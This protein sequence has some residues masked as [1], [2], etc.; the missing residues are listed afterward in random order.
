MGIIKIQILCALSCLLSPCIIAQPNSF[1]YMNREDLEGYRKGDWKE[2]MPYAGKEASTLRQ[3]VASHDFL[4]FNVR[5]NP[6]ETDN[7]F[8]AKLKKA[9]IIA[10]NSHFQQLVESELNQAQSG[11]I[12]VDDSQLEYVVEGEGKA[13]LVIGSSIY[14]PR[15]FSDKLRKH[16]KMYFV[17]MKWFAKGYSPEDLDQVNIASIVQDVEQIREALGLEKPLMMGHSI[18]GTIATEY[19]KKFGTQVSG[20]IVIGSPAE[21][22]NASYNEKAASLWA[23]AS[24]KRKKI[25]EENWGKTKEIDRLTGQEEA[26]ARYNNMSPQYWYNP[27]YD[28]SWLWA[29]MT[30]HSEVTQHLFTKVFHDYDMFD[31][32]IAIDVPVFLGLGKYDYV[33]PYTLWRSSYESIPDFHRVFFEKSGHTPQLEEVELFD[34]ELLDWLNHRF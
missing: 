11:L 12:T 24:P 16:L 33:I 10:D 6:K 26:S 17:D 19:V 30:V 4:L 28:A 21:W 2:K 3:A 31:P 20:L 18:H 29:D 1:L 14:Y 7:L 22:G 15:T 9:R 8:E 13:C 32:P 23:S 25:Q 34:K 5:E 27:E